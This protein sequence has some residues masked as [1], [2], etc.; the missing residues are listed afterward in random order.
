[1]R[2]PRTTE[3]RLKPLYDSLDLGLSNDAAL[4]STR[5]TYGTPV[6]EWG[7]G[8]GGEFEAVLAIEGTDEAHTFHLTAGASGSGTLLCTV[9]FAVPFVDPIVKLMPANL[10]AAG[11]QFYNSYTWVTP[12]ADGTGYEVYRPAAFGSGTTV[13]DFMA[14]V[15]EGAPANVLSI[16]NVQPWQVIQ[17]DPT[18]NTGT[19]IVSGSVGG[20]THEIEASWNGST[21]TTID[22][23]A[24]GTYSGTL[25]DL[26]PGQGSL[27]VRWA[28]R[29]DVVAAI[30][31]VGVG[32][33][34]VIGPAQSNG[35]GQGVSNRTYTRHANGARASI[36]RGDYTWRSGRLDPSGIIT[37]ALGDG[38]WV[39]AVNDNSTTGGGS[40]WPLFANSWFA[41]AAT[42]GIPIA[43]VPCGKN[44]SRIASWLPG[45]NHQ[46]RTTLYGAM[47]YRAKQA[48]QT[49]TV[50]G[51]IILIGEG[52]AAD[53][54]VPATFGSRLD[55]VTA[56]IRT[57]LGCKVLACT[58]GD[59][60]VGTGGA[61]NFAGISTQISTRS[62]TGN[63]L[64]GADLTGVTYDDTDPHYTE[65]A[66]LASV[67]TIVWAAAKAAYGF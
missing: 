65:N 46:D 58:L 8:L 45:A 59:P 26:T 13:M 16:T 32:D 37:A 1:M 60:P 61:A 67:N 50:R 27:S 47:V 56:A 53:G 28:E 6:I 34:F 57:D 55:T 48:S 31:K 52:D 54:T 39:D 25:T 64:A 15:S 40:L 33:I 49:G 38:A 43:F 3:Q 30:A 7:A 19:I 5:A 14:Q 10:T 63:Y 11:T 36:M 42:L 18:T 17:R 22:S 66:T 41:N 20:G 44:G 2:T 24:T 51:C 62:G 21:W 9:R 4:P 23:S 12:L 35:V 29:H